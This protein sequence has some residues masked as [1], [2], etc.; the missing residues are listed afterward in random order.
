VVQVEVELEVR[1]VDGLDQREGVGGLGERCAGMVDGRVEVLQREH[2]PGPLTQLG[3]PAQGLHGL[4]PHGGR[5]DL[6]REYRQPL[7]IEPRP[8]HV[9]A[10]AVELLGDLQRLRGRPEQPL[11]PVRVGERAGD[12]AGHRRERGTA[13]GERVDVLRR[14]VPDLHLVARVGDPSDPL[15]ERQVDEHHLGGDR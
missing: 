8:V 15:E 4:Q 10:R 7:R 9:E 13:A 6:G 3:E 12:V 5:D 2:P 14:P 1:A 11:R